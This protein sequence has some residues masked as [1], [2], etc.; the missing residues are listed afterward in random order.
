MILSNTKRLEAA[1]AA[2]ESYEEWREAAIEHDKKSGVGRWKNSDESK[3][4]DYKSIR[5]RLDRLRRLRGRKDYAGI[6]F[7]LNEGIHG[8]IDGMGRRPLYGKAKFGT[9]KLITEYVDEVA[10][11]LD[12]LASD[13]AAEI[14]FAERLDFFHRARHCYGCSALM[15]SGAGS[16][17]FFHVGVV[18]AMWLEGIL[19]DIISGSSGGAIVG[20]TASTQSDHNLEDIFEPENLVHEIERDQ[21]LLRHL[22]VFKP[23]VASTDDLRSAIERLIPDMTFLEAFKSTGRHLN[24]SIAAAEKHQT[25]RLLNSITTPNVFVREAV[26]ASAA[27]PGFFPPVGLAAKNSRGKRQAYLPAR[28]WVDGSLSD[29]LPAKRLSRVYGANHFIVSQVNPHVFPFVTDSRRESGLLSTVK[30]A[31]GRTTRE[32]L[33][34]SATLL[35]KPLAWNPTVSRLTNVGLSII[36]QDYVG[37]INILPD[38]RLFNPLKLL[39]HRSVSEVVKFIDMGERATWPKIEMIRI[40]TKIGRRLD[41]ILR[42]LDQRA[43]PVSSAAKR[44]AG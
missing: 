32:W 38:M 25:S 18:K 4:F 8:N 3:H 17:L 13:A 21:G 42:D 31:A 39:A 12:L 1:M 40:Q 23:E 37:D 22:A 6:L 16:L 14:P 41:R 33:N 2:A 19:P 35:E 36:N 11:A 20:A 7:A 15:M 34:A 27:V 28:K 26:M 43:L 9:K 44:R 24:I 5:R 30:S 29:D 10:N